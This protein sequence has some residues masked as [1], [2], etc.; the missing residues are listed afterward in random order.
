MYYFKGLACSARAMRCAHLVGTARTL[1][2]RKRSRHN[3]FAAYQFGSLYARQ[4]D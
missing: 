4:T 1:I 3:G 2:K